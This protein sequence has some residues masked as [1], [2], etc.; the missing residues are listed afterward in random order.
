MHNAQPPAQ[1]T[2]TPT[3]SSTRLMEL[4]L[5]RF[6]AA[7]LVLLFHYAFAGDQLGETNTQLP[8]WLRNISLYGFLGVDLFFV[9]SGFVIALSSSH[10]STRRFVF[11]RLV[12]LYPAFFAA[13]VLTML[14]REYLG[15]ADDT[16][17]IR[18]FALNLTLFAG[19]FEQSLDIEL[20][21]GV[22]WSLMVELQ[23]YFLF[24]LIMLTKLHKHLDSVLT[25][26]LAL[27][28]AS[29]YLA[30]PDWLDTLLI[31][32][33][34]PY[35]I[36]G[37]MFQQIYR[38][39]PSAWRISVIAITLYL[40]IDY[41]IWR[42]E[43]FYNGFYDY[44]FDNKTTG[45]LIG[46]IY[47]LFVLLVSNSLQKLRHPVLFWLGAMTYPVY[48]L[49]QNIGY[50]AIDRLQ[51]TFSDAQAL[52]ISAA[53]ILMLSLLVHLILERGL[54]RSIRNWGHRKMLAQDAR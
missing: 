27:T 13:V 48:L 35:F 30:F 26:W 49:H 15:P 34:S 10:G 12:R 41:G 51:G 50:I 22:Y 37:A 40:A 24:M 11:D 18:D 36:A 21:D 29:D 20:V 33:W 42:S 52:A 47:L 31:L 5:L 17:S 16:V 39:G 45:L 28:L 14:V 25:G 53:G 43:T 4:D 44:N 7:M 1:H 19:I 9:I 32:E 38:H 2:S 6:F 46:G 23:F 8:D 54:A 3:T